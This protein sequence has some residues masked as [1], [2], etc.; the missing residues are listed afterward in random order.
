MLAMDQSFRLHALDGWRGVCALLVA[1]FHFHAN[2]YYYDI[3]LI[4]N[5]RLA[6]DFFFVLSGFVITHAYGG[7]LR[8]WQDLGIFIARRLGR[9]YPLH[10]FTLFLAITLYGMVALIEPYLGTDE[11]NFAAPDNVTSIIGHLLLLQSMGL[12]DDFTWN[13]PSWSISVEFYVYVTFALLLLLVRKYLTAAALAL[14]CLGMAILWLYSPNYLTAMLDYGF[15]RALAGF[16]MGHLVY[17]LR[18]HYSNRIHVSYPVNTALQISVT[19]LTLLF[20]WYTPKGSP[21]SMLAPL[22]FGAVVFVFVIGDGLVSRGLSTRPFQFL[23]TYSYSI[24][25]VHHIIIYAMFRFTFV[26]EHGWDIKIS[27][28]ISHGRTM[29]YNA[30]HPWLMDVLLMVFLYIAIRLSVWCYHHIENPS[31]KWF[32]KRWNFGGEK[33]MAAYGCI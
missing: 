19:A 25:L 28:T 11:Y 31:R 16:S 23:G 5:G 2:G 13:A 22:L 24:Y 9:I 27:K 7:R 33:Q 26:I 21:F 6:V 12:Y 20:M 30:D 1:L 14:F 8:N 29:W 3:P 18:L 32:N 10:V 4:R 15:W 17:R